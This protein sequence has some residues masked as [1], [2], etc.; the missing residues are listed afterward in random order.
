MI[1]PLSTFIHRHWVLPS[2][3]WRG[4]TATWWSVRSLRFPFEWSTCRRPEL[5]GCDTR[6]SP[7]SA[8]PHRKHH[9]SQ[10]H[11]QFWFIYLLGSAPIYL[12]ADVLQEDL[13][14]RKCHL[15]ELAHKMTAITKTPFMT[16]TAWASPWHNGLKRSSLPNKVD[17]LVAGREDGLADHQQRRF[18][19]TDFVHHQ[20]DIEQPV[21]NS[22]Q[23]LHRRTW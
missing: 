7:P 16:Q 5:P 10:H 15:L 14:E 4:W 23:G 3:S 2:R 18:P 17:G 12:E 6:S 20:D 1:C 11:C 21:E 8:P 13:Q 22:L 9:I 19:S